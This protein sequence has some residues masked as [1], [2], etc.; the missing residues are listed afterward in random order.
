MTWLRGEAG[1]AAEGKRRGGRAAGGRIRGGGAEN[2]LPRVV[3]EGT[4]SGRGWAG[5]PL[6]L[7]AGKEN[8]G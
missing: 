3:G 7:Q 4:G 2:S 6:F 5:Q 1:D 8:R